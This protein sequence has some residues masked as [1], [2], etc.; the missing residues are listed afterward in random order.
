MVWGLLALILTI[1]VAYF[2]SIA[3][4]KIEFIRKLIFPRTFNEWK[5]IFLLLLFFLP[6][7]NHNDSEKVIF[8]G[9]S[10]VRNWDTERYMPLNLGIDG[11][12][13]ADCS[14]ITINNKETTVVLLAGTNDLT[15][16]NKIEYAEEFANQ[17]MKLMKN[18][19]CKRVVCISILP[20]NGSQ[21]EIISDINKC[22]ENKLKEQKNCIFLNVAEDFLYYERINPEYTVDGLHLNSKG[23]AL[24]SSKLSKIL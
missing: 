13:I 4:Y 1:A 11:Y 15:I 2:L 22:I 12:P 10:L 9:D 5:G 23:Y 21:Y 8:I 16:S 14:S 18:F 20:K 6:G 19:T 7:C 17:Y 24:L 3:I